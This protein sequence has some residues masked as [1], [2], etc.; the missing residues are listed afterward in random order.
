MSTTDRHPR[1][2]VTTVRFKLGNRLRYVDITVYSAEVIVPDTDLVTS[3]EDNS[4][5]EDLPVFGINAGELGCYLLF[6]LVQ[7]AIIYRGVESIRLLA[8]VSRVFA[9][10]CIS[11]IEA[12]VE[13]C[14]MFAESSPSLGTSLNPYIGYEKA[15]QVAKK[16]NKEG[17]TVREAVLELGITDRHGGVCTIGSCKTKPGIVTS[18]VEECTITL[19]QRHLDATTLAAMACG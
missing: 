5:F 17:K 4:L 10:K 19:D 9:D 16:V 8:N 15:A 14:K 1:A 7:V 11:G 3:G 2:H 6:W 13:R 18:V 12:N